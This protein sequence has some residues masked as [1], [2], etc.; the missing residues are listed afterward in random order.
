VSAAELAAGIG[1]AA[2]AGACFD[3]AVALQ[4]AEARALPPAPRAGA[5]LLGRLLRRPRWL[6]ATGLAVLGWPLQVAALALA[7]L[8]VVQPTLAAGL[9]V[10]LVAGQAVL[11]E[12]VG[13]RALAATAAIVAGVAVL[14]V[15]A[16]ERH[17]AHPDGAAVAAVLGMLGLVAALPWLARRRAG[18]ARGSDARRPSGDAP[19][20]LGAARAPSSAEGRPSGA[21]LLVAAAGAGYAASGLTSKLL[22]D[23]LARGAAGAA[24]AWT[25]VTALAAGLGL[26]DEMAALQRVNATRVAAGAF[27]VQVVVPVLCA[28]LLVGETWRGAPLG[29][30]GIV[31]G[32]LLV[33]GGALA[34][35]RAPAVSRLVAAAR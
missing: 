33:V 34:L 21:D 28:P 18:G 12:P 30:A 16:P 8:T 25:A 35:E 15:A 6:A 31:V 29:G 26:G 11:G 2:L 19:R 4:A 13:P 3:G 5:G 10:L 22:A 9:I 17:D 14:A 7:P 1:L 23:A 32:L 20:V 24:I 27:A